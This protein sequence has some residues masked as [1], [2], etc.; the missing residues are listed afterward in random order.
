MR[1]R[2]AV[3]A[4]R[5]VGEYFGSGHQKDWEA[6]SGRGGGEGWWQRLGERVHRVVR[7]EG[8]A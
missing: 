3:A 4:V 8:Q 7:M 6:G 5:G 2:L 1:A